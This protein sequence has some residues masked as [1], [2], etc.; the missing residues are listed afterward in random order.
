[1]HKATVGIGGPLQH[2]VAAVPVVRCFGGT[3]AGEF[4]IASSVGVRLIVLQLLLGGT[5]EVIV[6]RDVLEAGVWR[7]GSATTATATGEEV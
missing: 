2:L 4:L 7:T 6:R 5:V 1:M 3:G